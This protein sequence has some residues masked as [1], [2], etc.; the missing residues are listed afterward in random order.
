LARRHSPFSKRPSPLPAVGA[1]PA[2]T[3]GRKTA[4]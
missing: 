1:T 2:S 4:G 3:A